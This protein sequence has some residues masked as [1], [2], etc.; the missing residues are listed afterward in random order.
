MLVHKSSG[1]RK[2]T[3]IELVSVIGPGKVD[4]DIALAVTATFCTTSSTREYWS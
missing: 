3:A 1:A 2:P 4:F